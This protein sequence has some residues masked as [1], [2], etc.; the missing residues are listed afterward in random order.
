MSESHGAAGN[1]LYFEDLTVGRRFS[2]GTYAVTEE[3]IKA[4]AREFDPQPFHLDESAGRAS[5]LG[6]L[7]ASGWH[8]AA[9]T[10]RLIVEAGPWFAGGTLGMGAEVNWR[11]PVRPGDVLHAESEVTELVPS[12][13]R[14]DRGRVTMRTNTLN[15][16]GETVQTLISKLLVPRHLPR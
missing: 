6:G 1:G 14:A 15:A 16:R 8:T 3:K 4:F 11:K 9:I 7:A 10:M 2:T 12:R 5:L 13:S